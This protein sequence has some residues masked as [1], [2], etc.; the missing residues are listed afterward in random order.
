LLNFSNEHPPHSPHHT[1]GETALLEN[2]DGYNYE[3]LSNS[4]RIDRGYHNE[5]IKDPRLPQIEI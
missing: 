5:T 1:R 4:N 3:G 2:M